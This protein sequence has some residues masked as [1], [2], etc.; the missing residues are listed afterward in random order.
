M[1]SNNVECPDMSSMMKI[2]LSTPREPGKEN[3]ARLG[4]ERNVTFRINR[5]TEISLKQSGR[6]REVLVGFLIR[7]IDKPWNSPCNR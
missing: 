2:S 6:Y 3:Q 7:V 4:R 5:G 1:N